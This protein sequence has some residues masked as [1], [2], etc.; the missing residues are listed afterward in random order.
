METLHS[1]TLISTNPAVRGGRPC[2]AGTG[3]R[4]TDIVAAHLLHGRTAGEIASDFARSLAQ[5]HAAFAFYY[6][7][8][9][10]LD[11]DLREQITRTRDY[12]ERA[13][14]KRTPS[15]LP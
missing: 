4:V 13:V 11:A 6:E 3:L 10:A 8:K 5:V 15:L 12:Q 1:I 9:A 14:G 2:I 7:H